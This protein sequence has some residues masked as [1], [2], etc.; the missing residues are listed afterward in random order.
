MENTLDL[1]KADLGEV[2]ADRLCENLRLSASGGG[3]SLAESLR[4]QSKQLRADVA[5]WGE[6]NSKQGWIAGTAK[7]A[8]AAPWIVVA[9]LSIRPE[10]AAVYNTSSGVAILLVGFVVSVFAYRLIHFLG[11]LPQQPRVFVA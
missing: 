3:E 10:N 8:V 5:L 2:H 4:Q 7:L 9:M 1:L 11:T 6:L